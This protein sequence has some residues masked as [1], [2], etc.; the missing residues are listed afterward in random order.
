MMESKQKRINQIPNCGS[1]HTVSYITVRL[2]LSLILLYIM[3]PW[4]GSQTTV[5]DREHIETSRVESY[6]ASVSAGIKAIFENGF[7]ETISKVQEFFRTASE[8]I[9][10]VVAN[11]KMTKEL[12]ETEKEIFELYTRYLQRLDES[13][14]FEDKWK[15]RW[16]LGQLFLEANQIFE[17]F[18]IATQENMGIID[19]K[20]RI[21]LIKQTLIKAKSIKKSLRA[22]MRR[23]NQQVYQVKRQQKELEV[24]TNLFDN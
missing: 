6:S 24:F 4:G 2:Q 3:P 14:D 16:I 12:I 21:Q 15:Y 13:E 23:A 5:M 1:T 7:I 10:A 20:G 8:I 18:D 22:T 19:D 17:V 11:L 9:S